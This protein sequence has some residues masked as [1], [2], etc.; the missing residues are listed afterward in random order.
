MELVLV[1]CF[2]WPEIRYFCFVLILLHIEQQEEWSSDL[3]SLADIVPTC[4]IISHIQMKIYLAVSFKQD[5]DVLLD[6]NIFSVDLATMY[7]V[8]GVY[9]TK[10]LRLFKYSL[11]AH[12]KL[13][14]TNIFVRD[15]IPLDAPYFCV[16]P[17]TVCNQ[18]GKLKN[19]G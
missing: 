12:Y 14:I 2:Q 13:N 5:L 3:Q 7:N 15:C 8:C 4:C 10:A 11:V 1:S 18:K 16:L 17:D 9:F 6:K 19:N